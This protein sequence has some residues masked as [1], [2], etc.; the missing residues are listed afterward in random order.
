MDSTHWFVPA[1]HCVL[2]MGFCL[3]TQTG[4]RC[5]SKMLPDAG[6]DPANHQSAVG[7]PGQVKA[8]RGASRDPAGTFSP[9]GCP[10]VQVPGCTQAPELSMAGRAKHSTHIPDRKEWAELR[11]LRAGFPDSPNSACHRH[12][13]AELYDLCW[14]SPLLAVS[15]NGSIP[16]LTGTPWSRASSGWLIIHSPKKKKCTK[17]H[18]N[19]AASFCTWTN[20]TFVAAKHQKEDNNPFL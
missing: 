15:E 5:C 8:L 16:S 2:Q 10:G 11:K 12:L 4:V 19:I 14:Q 1:Q 13:W 20:L 9:R 18:P 7:L 6:V 3:L 17:H